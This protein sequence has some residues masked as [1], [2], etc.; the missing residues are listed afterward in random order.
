[1]YPLL[2]LVLKDHLVTPGTYQNPIVSGAEQTEQKD[3]PALERLVTKRDYN[4][5]IIFI[6]N[7]MSACKKQIRMKFNHFLL[8]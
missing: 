1:M 8:S 7:C 5:V 2:L 4:L 6:V 3:S